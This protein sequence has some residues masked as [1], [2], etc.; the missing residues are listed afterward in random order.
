MPAGGAGGFPG[1]MTMSKSSRQGR[2]DHKH[3]PAVTQD[4]VHGGG[5]AV[6]QDAD[7]WHALAGLRPSAARSGLV[8]GPGG[9]GDVCPAEPA[10]CP[11]LY[12]RRAADG[13]DDDVTD[14][15]LDRIAHGAV[16]D[17]GVGELEHVA[18]HRAPS[19]AVAVKQSVGR[20][21][22]GDQSELP[23]QVVR[24]YDPGVHALAPR[25]AVQVHRI[26]GQQHPATAIGVRRPAVGAEIRQPGGI[27]HG[28]RLG[29]TLVRQLLD[30]LQGGVPAPRDCRRRGRSAASDVPAS[31][32]RSAAARRARRTRA[33]PPVFWAE[34]T[35]DVPSWPP[36]QAILGADQADTLRLLKLHGSLNWYWTQGDVSGI[37]IARP[38]LPGVF[39]ATERHTEE[40]RRRV[41]PGRVP[42]VVP[43][44]EVKSPYY[45]NP[46]I[47]EIWQQAAASLRSASRVIILG[48]SLPPADLTFAGM[49]ADSLRPSPASLTIVDLRSSAVKDR[50]SGLGFPASRIRV[51]DPGTAPPVSAF[52]AQQ[53]DETSTDVVRQLGDPKLDSLDDPMI[54]VWGQEAFAAVVTSE[55]G[56]RHGDTGRRSGQFIS[57][58]SHP[59]P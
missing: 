51:L 14:P 1:S 28:D 57:P 30:L 38:D 39:G 35:G 29:R 24:V 7:V 23:A 18:C 56:R 25:R 12:R 54:V 47:R 50:L 42:F 48:C 41:L 19:G 6:S 26:A 9:A 52:T 53:R 32:S 8:I 10:D 36:G 22:G 43:P 20:P 11:A 31:G 33:P 3:V 49:L 46:V 40:Q 13:G 15:P 2:R 55:R 34:L 5:L 59:A 4:P 17:Q 45:R 58:G 16:A 21:A 37:S 27:G 44:S